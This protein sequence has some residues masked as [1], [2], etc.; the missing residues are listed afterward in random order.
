MTKLWAKMMDVDNDGN[1]EVVQTHDEDPANLWHPDALVSWR[2]VPPHVS[3]GSV[4]ETT[5]DIWWSGSDWLEKTL[6]KADDPDID[7]PVEAKPFKG[8]VTKLKIKQA[9]ENYETPDVR[10]QY[11]IGTARGLIATVKYD[12]T[13]E[14]AVSVEINDGGYGYEVG[15]TFSVNVGFGRDW[16][17][18]NPTYTIIEIES[19]YDAPDAV[20]RLAPPAP[21]A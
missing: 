14:S 5:T 19:V 3:I 15:Q 9:G 10:D 1:L 7:P 16:D 13:T 20:I 6:A 21:P 18:K 2:E 17:R 8:S 11:D 4:L 12:S